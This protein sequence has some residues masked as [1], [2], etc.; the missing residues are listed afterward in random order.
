MKFVPVLTALALLLAFT[1]FCLGCVIQVSLLGNFVVS[2]GFCRGGVVFVSLRFIFFSL[3][4]CVGV[5]CSHQYRS[6]RPESG[7]RVSGGCELLGCWAL[8]S[9]AETIH[10]LSH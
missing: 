6:Q 3:T 4:V 5:V 2:D 1:N 10:T 9:A 7:S 8:R